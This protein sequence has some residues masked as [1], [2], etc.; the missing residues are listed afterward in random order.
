MTTATVVQTAWSLLMG[1]Y[2]NSSDIV[3]G[4]TLNGRTAQL[5]GIDSI[6][7]PTI[8]TV[9]L[10]TRFDRNDLAIDVLQR[11]QSQY[12]EIM[13]F[14]QFGLQNI[15]HL[16]SGADSAC[17]F[18]TLLVIQSTGG[19]SPRLLSGRKYAFS[20]VDCAMMMECELNS[21]S[22]NLRATFDD[23]VLDCAQIGR[24]FQQFEH[25][26]SGLYSCDPFTKVSD[27]Q[28]ICNTDTQ[29]ILEWNSACNAPK[30]SQ[31]LIHT[32]FKQRRQKQPDDIAICAW[33]GELSYKELDE[34]SSRLAT[35]LQAHYGI[36][37]ESMVTIC[38]E[39]SLWV[40]V[41]MLAVLKAG[42]ACVPTDPKHPT[43][44]LK[45]IL[46]SL[47][48]N[49]ANLI[50]SSVVHA[51][52]LRAIGSRI[53]IVD[54]S[55]LDI[56]PTA[57]DLQSSTVTPSN[58]AF[59][60]F[61]SGS[62]GNPKGI[63]LEHSALCSSILAHGSFIQLGTHSRV[64]Q[65]AAHTFDISIGDIFATLIHG[66]CICI[67]SEHDRVNN[68]SGAI[69]SLKANHVSLTATV[70]SH[71]QPEEVP[72]LKFLVVAGEPMTRTVIENWADHVTLINMY[73]PAECTVYCIGKY[74][75]NKEDDCTDIGKG[76]GATVWIVNDQDYNSLTP[77]GGVGEILIE[78]PNL[79]RGYLGDE[80]QT[81]IAFIEDP[82]WAKSQGLSSVRRFYRTGDLGFY[83]RDASIGFAGRNDG[84]IKIIGQRVE[85]GEVEYQLQECLPDTIKSVVSMVTTKLGGRLLAAFLVVKSATEQTMDSIIARAPADLKQFQE[86]MDGI[87]KKLQ[88]L[89]PSYMVP[90][91]YAP[92]Y[93]I[94]LLASGK[95]DRK[96]LQLLASEMTTE[97]F[98]SFRGNRTINFKQPS[99][100]MEKRIQSLWE[101]ILKT[102]L[103][104]VDDNFF[105]LGGDSL[106]AM[107]LVSIARKEGITI[108][109]DQV[110]KN[111]ILS[112][113]A[114]ISFDE[115]PTKTMDVPPFS[116][117]GELDHEQLCSEAVLQCNI[118]REQIEDI[119]PCTL[120]QEVWIGIS[121]QKSAPNVPTNE[122][123]QVV[124]SLPRSLDL[125]RF[126]AALC[127]LVSRHAILRS[128]IIKTIAG[129]FQVVVNESA[130]LRTAE[131]LDEY[132]KN[133]REAIIECGHRLQRYCFIHV[134]NT[135]D[136]FFV[137]SA[138][139]SS[140]D[141]LTL[142]LFFRELET[143][144]LRGPFQE[145]PTKM[146]RLIKYIGEVD[147][148]AAGNFY[149]SYLAGAITK[150]LVSVPD[151][152]RRYNCTLAKRTIQLP[153][154]QGSDITRAMMYQAA[155]GI[156]IGR[157][158]GVL[159][160][161]ID[162]VVSGRNVPVFGIEDLVGPAASQI[163]VRVNMESDQKLQ[164]LL[165]S[166]RELQIAA[167]PFEHLQQALGEMVPELEQ[168]I[169]DAIK[170]NIMP[171]K[172][173]K[174]LGSGIGLK[175]EHSFV[176]FEVPF[177]IFCEPSEDILNLNVMSD[178]NII[179]EEHVESLMRR[180]EHVLLQIIAAHS[181][182]D[183]KV[184]DIDSSEIPD[185]DW[186]CTRIP[187]D[188]MAEDGN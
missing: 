25:I 15:R 3:T 92:I 2:S 144:Y 185:P 95:I 112:D 128:R 55:Q 85:I 153:N 170:I 188:W 47:A 129:V 6:I 146:N 143:T 141:A 72:C 93:R 167:M 178:K 109:V 62:T 54:A 162:T 17:N 12:I 45:T 126:R 174:K 154:H 14:E 81:K 118:R 24:I 145:P 166:L 91:I 39:K 165:Q 96:R 28:Q 180:F 34:Y 48:V 77:I 75:I 32:L 177:Y 149:R 36:G 51:D 35:H 135:N 11:V 82:A 100:R 168:L 97:E 7:G 172:D 19:H 69:Q 18:R 10:R 151:S 147:K 105:R 56:L 33:D 139:H 148:V 123:A 119:Y 80:A 107:R 53:L 29:Q 175:V 94:P 184:A 181:D 163:Y 186:S 155:W 173:T 132:L 179:S 27:L 38:F 116:L 43:G 161:I 134:K 157:E 106:T 63:V 52:R 114:L 1:I 160:V 30:Q 171:F 182:P 101:A 164:N 9:P 176:T 65:F 117:I 102:G 115:S 121:T 158:L 71:L 46:Q 16:S 140:Y 84:Q 120:Y 49:S 125:K 44:R 22:I 50:L 67:P 111:P 57:I 61:T 78:G 156:T 124:F 103:I 108:T 90:S 83:N 58:S 64:L 59:V 131:S 130:N 104:G 60:V 87:E 127:S 110:F 8:T 13:A 41:A 138:S 20:S 169:N 66:G 21:E 142:E 89:L 86:L 136:R 68:L 26:L 183:K 88:S 23:K 40:V 152:Y 74:G 37:P 150:P 42:G 113:M 76:V 99:S 73:G 159:D 187:W 98:S 79:A 31:T 133:D 122:Q 4:L 137:W 5:S 70:A